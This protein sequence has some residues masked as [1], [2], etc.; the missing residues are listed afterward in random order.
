MHDE[1]ALFADPRPAATP[2][3]AP[4]AET[5]PDWQVDNLRKS[6]DALGLDTM[7]QRQALIEE[8]AGRP[9]A[10]LRDLNFTEARTVAEA[11]AARRTD[12]AETGSAWDNRDGDTWIDRL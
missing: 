10:S 11:L 3:P 5:L 1:E 9:V 2:R 7:A 8:L 4:A 6:L 12:S